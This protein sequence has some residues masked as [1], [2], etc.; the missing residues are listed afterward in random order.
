M[1]TSAGVRHRVVVIGAGFGGLRVA[2]GLGG[3]AVDVT[4]V[5]ANNFHTFQPL[6]YQVATAGLDTDDIAYPV[7]GIFR[8]QANVDVRLA[9]VT[10]IDLAARCVHTDRGDPLGYDT[11]VVA[12]GTVSHDFGIPGVAEHTLPLKAAS[13]A[14]A[15]RDH[16]L[17]C[18]EDAAL[19]GDTGGGAL[20]VVVCGGG[21]TGVEMA[22]GL[23]ELYQRV[24]TKDFPRLDVAAARITLVEAAD[25]VLGAFHPTLGERARHTLESR[26]V[27]VITSAPVALVDA[28]RVELTG[29][30]VLTAQT[31]VWA[32]GVRASPVADL[33]GVELGRG[34]RIVVGPD[35]SVPGHPEVFAIGDIAVDPTE[36]LPQVAQPAIQGGRH[37]ARQIVRRL[38]GLATE[39]LRYRDKG[40]MATI[41]RHDAVAE[42]PSG[43]RLHGVV[44]WLAWLGL[45]LVYL[46][47][48][49]NRANVLV[50]WAWN[51]V[52][53]D[54]AS[55]L[56]ST[57]R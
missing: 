38:D 42:F 34:G 9:S 27:E 12:A 53:Y 51:Y 1:R 35:L 46:M 43:R 17:A 20:D 44:G 31:V 32:A 39:P 28:G 41:G 21:P 10:A 6:L 37:V 11:L 56:L 55:R 14:L 7:R 47:G 40:S 5:D 50:N 26:G 8:R 15:L 13:D 25:R 48:F 4:I 33:L 18:F 52:T 2:R 45:H 57:G 49:R 23:A 29:G 3:A 54:R 22:G 30:R 36:P 24:L 16:L 19:T